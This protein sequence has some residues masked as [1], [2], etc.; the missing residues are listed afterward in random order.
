MATKRRA[1]K[2]EAR[3]SVQQ[4]ESGRWSVRVTDTSESP[5]R[6]YRLDGGPWNTEREARDALVRWLARQADGERFRRGMEDTK[7]IDVYHECIGEP[8]VLSRDRLGFYRGVLSG[9][10]VPRTDQEGHVRIVLGNKK[11]GS[12]TRR[13]I[14][15]WAYSCTASGLSR[16]TVSKWGRHLAQLLDSAVEEGYVKENVARG[17]SLFRATEPAATEHFPY[18][19][20]PKQMAC[21][22]DACGLPDDP[23]RL[24]MRTLIFSGLRSGEVRALTAGSLVEKGTP[25]LNVTHSAADRAGGPIR[26]TPKSKRSRRRVPI[27]KDL[28]RDLTRHARLHRL[29]AEDPLFWPPWAQDLD[30]RPMWRGDSLSKWFRQKCEEADVRNQGESSNAPGRERM[31]T[32][33]DLRATGCS[34]LQMCGASISEIQQ[35]MGHASPTLTLAMYSVVQEWG[36]E[37]RIYQKVKEQSLPVG[38]ILNELHEHVVTLVSVPDRKHLH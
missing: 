17:T 38:D 15:E 18:L 22:I 7:L 29:G 34:V 35:W 33:H 30:S 4:L 10:A 9:E 16:S 27:P 32:P 1:P 23:E 20:T 26:K 36:Q 12:L 14:K 21:L 6:R 19:L 11:V 24:L 2:R 13:A 28:S 5:A 31:P 8:D 3:G 37:L 25:R